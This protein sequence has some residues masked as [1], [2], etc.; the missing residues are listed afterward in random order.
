MMRI[1]LI[2]CSVI[3]A[4]V[5]GCSAGAISSQ[6]PVTPSSTPTTGWNVIGR[7]PRPTQTNA[8]GITFTT[9]ALNVT[10]HSHSFSITARDW[11]TITGESIVPQ[12]IGV[13][14]DPT[15][16]PDQT[17]RNR[18]QYLADRMYP[19][20]GTAFGPVGIVSVAD[21]ST[22]ISIVAFINPTSDTYQLS[23]LTVTVVKS[24]PGT[25]ISSAE[26]YTT[27]STTLTIPGKNIYFAWL[28]SA[29]TANPPANSNS[30]TWNFHWGRLYDCGQAVCP[31]SSG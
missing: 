9:G 14:I 6:P 1:R 3:C 30:T 17:S 10:L 18:F 24:P 22:E 16:H 8:T 25:T 19:Y 26:F 21:G 31:Q 5:T 27:P 29:V 7:A 13:S 15:I 12:D 20:V 2:V 23:D 11:N 4:L 28:S